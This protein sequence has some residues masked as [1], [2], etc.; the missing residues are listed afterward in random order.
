MCLLGLE[1]KALGATRLRILRGHGGAVG[2]AVASVPI[3][4]GLSV[5]RLHV[6]PVYLRV[7]TLTKKHAKHTKET[8]LPLAS[9]GA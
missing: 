4:K 2:S 1:L 6:L 7:G 9:R 8:C 5:W 3:P